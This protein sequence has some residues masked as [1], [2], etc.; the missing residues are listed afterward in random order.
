MAQENKGT[1]TW[2][3]SVVKL[4]KHHFHL[5]SAYSLI[6]SPHPGPVWW[7][8]PGC[9]PDRE[10]GRAVTSWNLHRLY[11]RHQLRIRRQQSSTRHKLKGWK[12]RTLGASREETKPHPR[13]RPTASLLK[14]QPGGPLWAP[15]IKSSPPGYRPTRLPF[16]GSPI[17]FPPITGSASPKLRPTP[18]RALRPSVARARVRVVAGSASP[19]PRP[20]PTLSRRAS[21]PAHSSQPAGLLPGGTCPSPGPPSSRTLPKPLTPTLCRKRS[22]KATP[23]CRPSTGAHAQF[24]QPPLPQAA[25]AVRRSPRFRLFSV[26]SVLHVSVS[27]LRPAPLVLGSP[28]TLASPHLRLPPRYDLAVAKPKA[29]LGNKKRKKESRRLL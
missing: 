22:P 15:S 11:V 25:R 2:E 21:R 24:L 18:A 4:L 16:S 28:R 12:F 23:Q 1:D 17:R 7:G 20:N 27:V 14:V 8:N 3:R 9:G 13:P 6:G 19:R 10:E 5:G 26:F 29:S